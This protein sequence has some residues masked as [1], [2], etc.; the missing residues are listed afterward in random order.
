MALKKNKQTGYNIYNIINTPL[1]ISLVRKQYNESN[2]N[3][4][5]VYIGDVCLSTDDGPY[6]TLSQAEYVAEQMIKEA[7][8][9]YKNKMQQLD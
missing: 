4:W 7:F 6:P 9:E 2:Q 3:E 8:D 1:R 5:H